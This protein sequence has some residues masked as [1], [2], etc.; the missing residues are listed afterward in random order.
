MIDTHQYPKAAGAGA[1]TAISAVNS[2]GILNTNGFFQRHAG[3][4][5]LLVS[6]MALCGECQDCADDGTSAANDQAATKDTD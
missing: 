1:K 2:L 4:P 5:A 6:L 3:R